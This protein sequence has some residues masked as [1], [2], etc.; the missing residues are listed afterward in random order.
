MRRALQILPL[1]HGLAV[2][3]KRRAAAA[4]SHFSNRARRFPGVVCPVY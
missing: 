1:F 3:D 2:R 4:P